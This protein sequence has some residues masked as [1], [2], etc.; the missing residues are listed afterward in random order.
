M[1]EASVSARE[2]HIQQMTR[3]QLMMEWVAVLNTQPP[4]RCGA[5]FLR[6]NLLHKSR[7]EL[8]GPL[9]VPTQQKLRKMYESFKRSPDYE[10]KGKATTL[11]P[12]TKLVR[13]YRG[14]IHEVMALENG[15]NYQGIRYRS[16]SK[17][18]EIITGTRWNGKVFFGLKET[19]K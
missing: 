7:E 8:Y 15:Y 17:I 18:A 5:T 10:P 14:A 3:E 9:R 11:R 12:G 2:G 6:G 13:E 19:P 1:K 4:Q 16:L